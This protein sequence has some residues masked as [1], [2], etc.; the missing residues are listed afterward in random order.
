MG[1]LCAEKRKADWRP[2]TSNTQIDT[3]FST[4]CTQGNLFQNRRVSNANAY[5][6]ATGQAPIAW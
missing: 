4:I 2:E 6:L 3:S 5:L 1:Q